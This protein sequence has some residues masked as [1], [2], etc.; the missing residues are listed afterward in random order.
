MRR[1][2]VR[3]LRTSSCLAAIAFSLTVWSVNP[4]DGATP[5][6]RFPERTYVSKN[7]F[8]LYAHMRDD[9]PLRCLGQS[10]PTQK[11]VIPACNLW[12]VKM[13]STRIRDAAS[14]LKQGT[15][16]GLTG[17]PE[18]EDLAVLP[19]VQGLEYLDLHAGLL[20]DGD[21]RQLAAIPL[22]NT[23]VLR[24]GKQLSDGAFAGLAKAAKLRHLH[25]ELSRSFTGRG[26][27][28]L[29]GSETLEVL[30]VTAQKAFL[31]DSIRPLAT[32]K[33]LCRL[34]LTGIGVNDDVLDAVAELKGLEE[35]ALSGRFTPDKLRVLKALPRLRVL[36][37]RGA[38]D[39]GVAALAQLKDLEWIELPLFRGKG[40]GLE[41]LGQLP[42]L[43]RLHVSGDVFGGMRNEGLRHIGALSKLRHLEIVSCSSLTDAGIAYV[44]KLTDLESLKLLDCRKLTDEGISHLKGL[45]RLRHLHLGGAKIGAGCVPHIAHLK[46]LR[47]LVME[48]TRPIRAALG[49]LKELKQLKRLHLPVNLASGDSRMDAFRA[50]QVLPEVS[51]ETW[52][53]DHVTMWSRV[54]I[55]RKPYRNWYSSAAVATPPVG[56]RPK[57]PVPVKPKARPVPLRI[58]KPRTYKLTKTF[59]LQAGSRYLN[60]IIG[61]QAKRLA[62]TEVIMGSAYVL[63]MAS[64]DSPDK[65]AIKLDSSNRQWLYS[66]TPDGKYLLASTSQLGRHG[67][68]EGLTALYDC[69][70]GKRIRTFAKIDPMGGGLAAFGWTGRVFA[71]AQAK[72]GRYEISI[73]ETASERILRK[74]K[75][76]RLPFIQTFAPGDNV[77]RIATDR[78]VYIWDLRKKD[79]EPVLVLGIDDGGALVSDSSKGAFSPDG[80]KFARLALFPA[81]GDLKTGK[82]H[83]PPQGNEAFAGPVRYCPD[84]SLLVCGIRG[85]DP[86]TGRQVMTFP[87]CKESRGPAQSQF[88][89]DGAK[90]VAVWKT[91]TRGRG[92]LASTREQ[93]RIYVWTGTRPG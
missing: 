13:V 90:Y 51:I 76:D 62:Y 55:P 22:L 86:A 82:W 74:G 1:R 36:S 80:G 4:A 87:D 57:P 45:G 5:P 70:T 50:K 35:L 54:A 16:C 53:D 37:V 10:R 61:P 27:A 69:A 14:E 73:V 65:P 75:V 93:W 89:A 31:P 46:E 56:V 42:K 11:I 23:L 64:F 63:K 40:S 12:I 15:F 32:M 38:K 18:S 9:E 39:E 91:A 77:L 52:A 72:S 48:R 20:S 83:R 29:A 2:P 88:T 41:A 78:N 33:R 60:P 81:I 84:G 28:Q 17:T 66:F 58:G 43:R 59:S 8:V 6:K 25:I 21:M 26:L 47:M 34:E 79:S 85:L 68:R 30:R 19:R 7:G 92:R 44:G 71:Y 49:R 3:P 24:E 67:R